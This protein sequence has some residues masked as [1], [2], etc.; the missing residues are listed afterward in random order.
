MYEQKKRIEERRKRMEV[1]ERQQEED[2]KEH[3]A[4]LSKMALEKYVNR[5]ERKESKP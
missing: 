4:R 2:K 1:L 5:T 3:N